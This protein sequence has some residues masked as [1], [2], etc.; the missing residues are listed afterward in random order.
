VNRDWRD[1][2]VGRAMMQYM[3]DWCR[4]NLAVHRLELWVFPDNPRAIHLYEKMG[5]QHEGNRRSSF[6][7]EGRMRD[8][9]LMAMLFER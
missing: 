6:L 4:Y 9:L 3:I 1:Q 2:G 5:F 8:L 7:K